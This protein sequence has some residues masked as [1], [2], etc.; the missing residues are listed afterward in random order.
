MLPAALFASCAVS[1]ITG[2]A[3]ASLNA[4]D[5]TRFTALSSNATTVRVNQ[6][7]QLT[8]NGLKLGSPMTFY[9]NGIQG[10]D[11][12]FGTIDST[13]LYTAPAIVPVP[14]SVIITAASV[15]HPTFRKGTASVGVLNPIPIISAVSPATFPEGSA[16]II[17]N[18]SEFV[19][20]AQIMLNGIAVP[21]TLISGA[22]LAAVIPA[23]N[24][25]TFPLLVTNPNPGAANSTTVPVVVGPG[26]V[27]LTLYAGD[28]SDVRVTNPLSFGLTVNGTTNTAVTVAVNGIPNGNAQ[29]GTV[30]AKA[31]GAITYTAPPVVPTP[32]NAVQLTITSV[33]NPAVSITQNISVL[34][35]IPILNTASP[36]NY[37]IGPPS[38]TVTLTGASFING[39]Q[40]LM[41]GAPVPKTFVGGTQLTATLSPTES[42][43]PDL[44]VLNPSPGPATSADLIA[45]VNGTDHGWGSHHIVVGGAVQGQDMYGQYPVVGVNQSNDVGAGRLIPTTSVDQYAATL[46]RWFGLS[47]G[48]VRQVFPN[49]S[50]FGS[51]PYLG[52]M[53]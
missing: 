20:G 45:L 31:D 52:F 43:N 7:I 4:G 1:L 9:V 40:V 30:V 42:G 10:G 46:A 13:D 29:I 11:S 49:F 37:N 50:N 35:P 8:N 47:D 21:T 17:V 15:D 33:D 25:G 14:N 24:P 48:Q 26:R 12:K 53:G 2:C 23:P 18:G 38:T 28:G 16:Q 19:F 3:V 44:Q 5:Q 22:Q 27:V 34:N 32:S 39:A 36:M 41:N 51:S 6:Q